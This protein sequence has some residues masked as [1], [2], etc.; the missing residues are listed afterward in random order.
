M[1]DKFSRNQI[2]LICFLCIL[3]Y[4]QIYKYIRFDDSLSRR[5]ARGSNTS[6]QPSKD[7]NSHDRLRL[8]REV[9]DRIQT[10]ILTIYEPSKD[11][12]VDER[13]IPFRG[14]CAFRV[15]MKGKPCRYGIKMWCAVDVHNS[16]LANFDIYAGKHLTF[17]ILYIYIPLE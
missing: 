12:T 7:Q 13:M 6:K 11:V 9:S 15:Y 17:Y 14:K 2:H 16:M 4:E 3:R 1:I 5:P 8:I 10:N